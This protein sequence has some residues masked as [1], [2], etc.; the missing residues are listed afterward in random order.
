MANENV[1]SVMD[2]EVKS[3]AELPKSAPTSNNDGYEVDPLQVAA[4]L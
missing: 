4:V 3:E 2:P 1:I